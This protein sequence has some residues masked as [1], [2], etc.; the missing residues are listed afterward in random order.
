M[1]PEQPSPQCWFPTGIQ[2]AYLASVR[3]PHGTSLLVDTGSPGNITS[4]GWSED[5]SRE[6]AKAGLPQPEIGQLL[7]GHTEVVCAVCRVCLAV[8]APG[9]ARRNLGH[10]LVECHIEARVGENGAA[11]VGERFGEPGHPRHRRQRRQQ[12]RQQQRQQHQW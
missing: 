10:H 2:A 6:L 8:A 5:H 9:G 4:D 3:L 12:Q 7:V 1:L 11:E